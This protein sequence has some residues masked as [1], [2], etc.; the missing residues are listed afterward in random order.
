MLSTSPGYWRATNQSDKILPCFNAGACNGGETGA[1]LFC[2]HGYMGYC[3]VCGNGYTPSLA[4]SCTRCSRSRRQGLM[5]ATAFKIIIVVWQILTQ[6][7]AAANVT[8]P[9]VYQD[10]LSA[11][12]TINV[13]LGF[14]ISAGCLWSGIDFHG[15]LLVDTIGP[16]L[17]TDML[18]STDLVALRRNATAGHAIL[19]KIRHKHVTVLLLVT[20][21]VYSSVSS[22]VFQTFA[23]NS[24]DDGN[25]Y[26][27]ADYRIFCTTSKHLALQVYAG[28]MV[29][30]YPVGIPLLHAILLFQHRDILVNAS[31]DKA[32]T[33]PIASLWEACKPAYAGALVAGHVLMFLAISVEVV[34]ICYVSRRNRVME[35]DKAFLSFPGLRARATSDGTPVF[36]RSPA[37]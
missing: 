31:A 5:V 25:S 11:I 3:A 37:S 4:H 26:L 7:A 34:G 20:F 27:R 14:M 18:A 32:A 28:V 6:F 22:M 10:F 17:A 13:D 33:Q 12:D 15:R 29:V 21:L 1:D 16:L 35:E 19:E 8:Y 2:A 23:C 9:R 30:V 24:L 36:E